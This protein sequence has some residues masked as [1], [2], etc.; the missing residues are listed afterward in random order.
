MVI[1]MGFIYWIVTMLPFPE[2]F[3]QIALAI[4][5]VI[6]LMY[7]LSLLFGYAAPFP[8]FRHY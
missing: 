2:P 4:V 5:G 6:C 7:L 3:K 1:I 8:V